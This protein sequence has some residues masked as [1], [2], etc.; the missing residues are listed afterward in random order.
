MGGKE[1]SKKPIEVANEINDLLN[2]APESGKF[3]HNG[4]VRPW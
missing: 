2:K 4:K 3:W 1:A